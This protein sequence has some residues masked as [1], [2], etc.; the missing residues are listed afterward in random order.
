MDEPVR[1]RPASNADR[2]AVRRLVFAI[3]IEHGLEPDHG[4]TD[5]DLDDIEV[6]Y[7]RPGGLFDVAVDGSGAVVGTVGLFSRGGGR[8]ELRKMYVAAEHRGRGL[9]RR[10]VRHAIERARALG[11]RRVELTTA[12]RLEAAVHLYESAGFRPF[13]PDHM[14]PRADRGYALDLDEGPAPEDV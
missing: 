1:L 9:G 12:I 11:F 8:C 5:A 7:L 13:V 3:L 4:S 2:D 10:L 14:P 6:S